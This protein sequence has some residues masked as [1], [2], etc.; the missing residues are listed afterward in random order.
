MTE[1]K[2]EK[3][4]RS[5]SVV[6]TLVERCLIS[7]MDSHKMPMSGANFDHVIRLFKVKRSQI[8]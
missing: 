3:L 7:R 2:V 5:K 1:R 6:T 8:M 4:L